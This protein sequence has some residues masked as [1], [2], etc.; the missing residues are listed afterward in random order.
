MTR[1]LKMPLGTRGRKQGSGLDLTQTMRLVSPAPEQLF[2]IHLRGVFADHQPARPAR[3]PRRGEERKGAA[4]AWQPAKAGCVHARVHHD[5][6]ETELRAAQSGP[7]PP[8][9]WFRSDGIHPR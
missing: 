4:P 7:R 1:G 9:E 5:A 3:P 2:R 8:D 6:E